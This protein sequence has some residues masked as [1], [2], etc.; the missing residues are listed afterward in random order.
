MVVAIDGI[1]YGDKGLKHYG[2]N[3]LKPPKSGPMIALDQLA[4]G[5]LGGE[6]HIMLLEDEG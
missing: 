4:N 3:G 2:D 5:A 1:H 6:F